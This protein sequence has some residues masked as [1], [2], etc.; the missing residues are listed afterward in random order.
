MT[1]MCLIHHNNSVTSVKLPE[2]NNILRFSL[3]MKVKSF[4]QRP[5]ESPSRPEKKIILLRSKGDT[6]HLGRCS[7]LP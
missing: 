2:L 7:L 6:C 4:Q 5:I 3:K 1:C